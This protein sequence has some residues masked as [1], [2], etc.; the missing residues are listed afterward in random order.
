MNDNSQENSSEARKQAEDAND[1]QPI[2]PNSKILE[3]VS[4]QNTSNQPCG[5]GNPT[6][7]MSVPSSPSYVYA[8]GRIEVRFGNKSID[9]EFAQATGRAGTKGLTDLETMHSILLQKE[10]RYLV[11]QMCW[12]LIIEGIETYV[13][14]PRNPSDYDLLVESLSPSPRTTD[15]D[16]IIGVKGPLADPRM[17]NGLIAP[18]AIFDQIYSFDTESLIKAV[19]RPGNIAAKQFSATIEELFNR[20]RLMTHNA[21]ETDEHRAL[22]Y[23]SVRYE[24]IYSHT[25]EMFGRNFS[26]S[27]IEVH[28][29]PLS[30]VRKILDVIFVY[31]DRNTDVDEKYYTSVDVTEEFPFLATK[32]SPY[33]GWLPMSREK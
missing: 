13:L 20:I 23:L 1:K 24:R 17:C 8:T 27:A 31:T 30:G 2:D 14:V 15:I 9:K 3:D 19:P 5:C 33:Y 26:L 10:N 28:P 21:G 4:P 25:A 18:I 7:T 29:S 11:R 16:V 6:G 32:L 12:V 22:N